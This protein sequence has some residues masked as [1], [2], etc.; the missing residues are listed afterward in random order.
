M[1]FFIHSETLFQTQFEFRLNYSTIHPILD[2]L[3]DCNVS[4]NLKQY[5]TMIFLHSKKAFDSVCHQKLIKKLNFYGISGVASELFSSYLSNRSQFVTI[6]NKKS[7]F[8]TI[9]YGVP[10]GFVLGPLLFLIYIN[11]QLM[12]LQTIPRLFADDT[13]LTV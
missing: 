4:I 12:C 3:I 2:L 8:K 7:C 13:A 10:Q 1:S 5:S 6:N 9:E 11:D